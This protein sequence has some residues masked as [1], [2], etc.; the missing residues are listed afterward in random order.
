MSK[1]DTVSKN[2][3]N[4]IG[5]PYPSAL[6][7]EL[8]LQNIPTMRHYCRVLFT[9]GLSHSP[10][11]GDKYSSDDYAAYVV[12][13]GGIKASPDGKIPTKFVSSCQGFFVNALQNGTVILD[14]SVRAIDPENNFFKTDNK[15]KNKEEKDRIWLNL[16]NDQGVFN[17]ILI[18]F[19]EDANPKYDSNYDAISLQTNA[20]TS[21]YSIADGIR[22]T[23]QGT[24]SLAEEHRIALGLRSAIE[25]ETGFMIGI[26]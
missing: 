18:G 3:W 22:F 21:F 23:I 13:T 20:F 11:A 24:N 2:N 17:Q 1:K 6:D 15:D 14:N 19:F 7:L 12:G 25:E 4:F 10:K 16:S 8:L 9:S 5:N 26:R